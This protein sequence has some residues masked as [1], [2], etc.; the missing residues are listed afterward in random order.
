MKNQEICKK[1]FRKERKGLFVHASKSRDKKGWLLKWSA[2][3]ALFILVFAAASFLKVQAAQVIT[4]W[5][6]GGSE[7]GNIGGTIGS[8]DGNETG[9]GWISMSS[10]NP[11]AGRSV[12]YGVTVD[13]SGKLSGYAWSENIGW[14]SFNE[15][16]LTGCPS[17]P[18]CSATLSSDREKLQGW[19]RIMSIPQAGANA[20]GWQG[21]ISLS[22]SNPNDGVNY[23]VEVS[24]MDGTGNSPTY[25]WSD[26]LGWI[27]FSRA[28]IESCDPPACA[29]KVLCEGDKFTTCDSSFCTNGGSCALT[30]DTTWK[31]TNSCGEVSC[32]A[33]IQNPEDGVCGPADE[34]SF[35]TGQAPTDA[36]LCSGGEPDPK[37]NLLDLNAYEIKWQ[38]LGSCGGT[39]EDCSARG[40]KACGWIE[41]NP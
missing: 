7:D 39:S 29:T 6:W 13:D 31:C 22:D 11:G 20:G 36:D 25:A 33:F 5:L 10:T 14:V 2:S 23:G 16:D 30:G 1:F 19:A 24:K 40:K 41:T 26:E 17:A 4:G 21:W 15:S 27:D 8:I 18:N 28:K 37:A 9:V 35:C 32:S 12:S 34:K 38:C 3:L